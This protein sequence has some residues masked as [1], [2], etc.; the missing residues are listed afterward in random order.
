[1]TALD[2]P[3][4]RV[5]SRTPLIAAI[6]VVVVVV[7]VAWLL[8]GRQPKA[9]SKDVAPR[10]AAPVA[11]APRAEPP[12][13]PT[14]PPPPA[15]GRRAAKAAKPAPP[16]P[17]EPA[18]PPLVLKVS[19]DVVGADVFVDRVY[20]GKAPLETSD[21]KPGSHVLNVSAEGY[22]SQAL[23]VEVK[24]GVNEVGVQFK[25]VR[26]DE[27]IAVVHK[28]TIGSCEGKLVA[29]PRGLRYET[30]N[31][32]H[33]FDVPFPQVQSFTVDYLQKNLRLTRKDGKTFNFTDRNP[34]ADALF[35]FHRKVEAARARLDNTR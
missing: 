14:E 26:L 20:V 22:E 19:S 8:F 34:N 33:A 7:I 30:S 31:K 5:P 6:A 11:A 18:A 15:G 21:V 35:V 9:P 2:Q 4:D 25:V 27:S 17:A 10:R 16:P 32:D 23:T 29:T 28:H 1:M 24:E 13:V 12:P 3:P